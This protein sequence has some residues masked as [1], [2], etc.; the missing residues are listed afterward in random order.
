MPP[1]P[2]DDVISDEMRR[3]ERCADVTSSL[4]FVSRK[5]GFV[6]ALAGTSDLRLI[7]M[8]PL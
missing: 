2:L 5:D 4:Q 3:E 8:L 6:C 7:L 1:V